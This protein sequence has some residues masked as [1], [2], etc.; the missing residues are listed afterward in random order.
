MDVALQYRRRLRVEVN[1]LI[2]EKE[3]A[4]RARRAVPVIQWRPMCEAGWPSL[5]KGGR[6]GIYTEQ[7]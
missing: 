6:E 2:E 5:G 7:N 1:W 3:G 4:V